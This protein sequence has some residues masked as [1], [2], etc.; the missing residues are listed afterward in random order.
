MMFCA[1]T[2][3]ATA[4]DILTLPEVVEEIKKE[5]RERT[6]GFEYKCLVPDNV[7]PITE[8][9]VKHHVKTRW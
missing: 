8:D 6:K 1:R 3:G 5:H 4:A 9:F 7:K 2:L